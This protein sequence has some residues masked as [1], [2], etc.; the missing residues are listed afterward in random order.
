MG[1]RHVGRWVSLVALACVLF[2]VAA[3][4]GGS[5]NAVTDMDASTFDAFGGPAFSGDSATASTCVKSSCAARGFECGM[6]GDGCGGSTDC[7]NCPTGQSCGVG[8]FSKCG[9]PSIAVDGGV[10]CSPTS[11][12]TL[13]Y[14]CGK[15]ADGCGSLIDCG[16][17]A[18][19]GGEYCGGSG[20]D[21]CGGNFVTTPDGGPTCTPA[22]CASLG[23]N[24]GSAGDGCGG[25]I[26]PCGPACTSPQVCGA[27]KP[28]VCGSDVPCTGLCQQQP[29][30]TGGSTT[31]ITGTVRAGL[32]E[33]T[34]SWVPAGAKPDPVPG[35]LVYVP[36][37]ALAP[38]D[39][40][41]SNPQ[42]QCSQCGADVSGNPLVSTTTA[43]DGTFTLP[44]V[45][46]SNSTADA[47]K[48]PVVIQLGRWRRLFK[49][50]VSNKCAS[51]AVGDLNMPSTS[52]EGDIP[53]TAIST[54]SYDSIECVLLK[55]GVS[56]SEFTSYA[57]WT[58]EAA[59]GTAPKPG[60][61]HIYTSTQASTGFGIGPGARLAPQQDESVLMG[62][63]NDAGPSNGT[64]MKYDQILL[65]CWG[66]AFTK[67]PAELANLLSYGNAGGR[68]FATH[69]SYSWLHG[70]G[71][72]DGT[73]QWDPKAN[74][75]DTNPPPSG[76][77]FT[78]DVSTAVP[79]TNPGQFVQW[80]NLVGALD[81]SNPGG[82]PPM[83]PTVTINA[84]RHDVDKVL[85]ASTDWID[86]TDPSPPS[87]SK[88]QM[89]LHFT[90]D[91]PIG[92]T[93]QCGHAIYS[94]FHV[95]GTTSNGSTFPN[96]CDQ[97][98][99][100]AQERIL[101]YMIW[102]LSSCVPGPPSPS[103][104]TPKSCSDQGLNCGPAGDTCGNLIA[105]GCGTCPAGQT[106]GGGGTSGVCGSPPT[107]TCKP[108]TCADQ[109]ITCGP[110]GDGC[111]GVTPNCGMC[112][113]PATCGGGGVP[114]QCGGTQGCVPTTCQAQGVNCGPSGDGCGNLIAS[115][116]TCSP[117]ETC[118]GGGTPG[119]CG[120]MM[121]R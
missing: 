20:F 13:G 35:V 22:T 31:T 47:D 111:G 71:A 114:G 12:P 42:V 4:C 105:G 107:G 93:S 7:G 18:C 113:P 14:D 39:A 116:G 74:P 15:T 49:F 121:T 54:G 102:D 82:A 61:I 17:V 119:V 66:D 8:G 104:C 24:C 109:G 50:T 65:P 84:G 38:F 108:E 83:T 120:T 69:Y 76:Q 1:T 60:R 94:D 32:Q 68:F 117:P 45:P 46:L 86:G 110:A 25:T 6:N 96:E 48:I 112:T 70:N 77:P 55:M 37:T 92:Q 88:S 97:L 56:Q 58:G 19:S 85:G 36:Q 11:C 16:P 59:S 81:A 87:A 52:A 44:N 78:G 67:S 63:G 89:L 10:A 23:Y 21:K 53:L 5:S 62:A 29:A 90:F 30:C 43:F 95:N 75:N 99:L 79:S 34:T 3:S 73:A 51:N 57:T 41:P 115:C 103:T 80:L 101:E 106:C 40:D 9:N 28:N 91:M 26:G 2:L 118:G 64:Y 100:T 27:V 72:F 33:G 98:A